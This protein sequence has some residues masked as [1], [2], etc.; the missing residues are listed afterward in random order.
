MTGD[1]KRVIFFGNG[2]DYSLAFLQAIAVLPVELVGIVCPTPDPERWGWAARAR[3]LA[4]KLPSSV[5]R[6][7][8]PRLTGEFPAQVVRVAHA[9][10]AQVFWPSTINDHCLVEELELLAPDVVVMAGFSEILAP[11]VL[12]GLG[13]ILNIHPSVLPMHRGPHP[14]FWTIR[15]GAK[16]GGVTIH[17]VDDGIDTGNIVAQ[18]RFELEP[19]LTGGQLQARAIRI[20]VFLLR[21]VLTADER[22]SD[23][24]SWPQ[25][26]PESYEGRIEAEDLVLPF[27]EPCQ[28]GYDL[29]R[30]GAP[31][32]KVKTFAPRRW[33]LGGHMLS[34]GSLGMGQ[35]PDLIRLQL[36]RPAIFPDAEIGSPGTIRRMEGGSV[37]IACNPGVLTFEDVTG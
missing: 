28:V 18:E 2:Y 22:V 20:G 4:L 16:E 32:L 10:G 26:G 24:P 27:E 17:R 29:A 30:A 1:P 9:T 19:W 5:G 7:M 8:P 14:E 11:V 25:E 6:A 23:L 35:A 33:W 12:E 34:T 31:W 37:A 36:A 3:Q 13:P 21:D 15:L